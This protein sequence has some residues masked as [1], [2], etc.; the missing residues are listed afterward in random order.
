MATDVVEAPGQGVSGVVE[1]R[2]IAIGSRAFLQAL[3]KEDVDAD[4]SM[5][6][7][8]RAWVAVDGHVAASSTM[9]IGC[10]QAHTSLVNSLTPLGFH[11]I[12][13]LSGDDARNAID[14]AQSVGITE[15]YAGLLP[16]DKVEHVAAFAATGLGVMMVGDGTNDA[17]ALSRAD[18][19]IALAGHGGGIT[20]E[21]ADIVVLTD[22][23]GLIAE[24][25]SIGRRTMRVARESIGV[26][27]A[28][29]GAAMMAAS[30]GFITR[31]SV[32]CCRKRLTWPSSSTHFGPVRHP[33]DAGIAPSG[34]VGVASMA[35]S[36]TSSASS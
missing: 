31:C 1:G 14:V 15:V 2:R 28:L 17:P 13:L 25:V 23:L 36:A 4:A 9:P 27:L 10:D 6:A 22:D 35:G 3:V 34:T 11:R 24:A 12:V 30:L 33:R 7:A 8:L 32:R 5:D 18:V 20:A 21:A 26:G 29:S 19:G 16:S